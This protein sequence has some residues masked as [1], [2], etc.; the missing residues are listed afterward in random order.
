MDKNKVYIWYSGATDVTGKALVDKLGVTGGTEKPAADAEM[1]I[2]WGTKTSVDIKLKA[3]TVLN[4]PNDIRKNRNKLKAMEA[5]QVSGCN[6]A[7]FVKSVGK[8]D[9]IKVGLNY[10]LVGRTC[11]HQAG[12]G[13]WL[14]LNKTQ[15][16]AAINEGADYFQE[17]VHIVDEYRLHVFNDKVVYAVKKIRRNNMKEAFIEQ[18]GEKVNNAAAKADKKLD[19]D[20]LEYVLGKLAVKVLPNA[21]M[22]VR[23][24][25]RGWKFSKVDL[26]KLPKGLGEQAI[27]ALKGLNMS[28]GAVDCCLDETG[29]AWV[30]EVN[31]GPGL[32]GST[33]E[34]YLE[35]FNNIF[36]AMDK[37]AAEAVK[38]EAPKKAMEKAKAAAIVEDKMVAAKPGQVKAKE[39][40]KARLASKI[41]VLQ[42]MLEVASEDEAKVIDAL[43]NKM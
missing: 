42:K 12:K 7:P 26:N 35:E 28:F 21:D 36:V 25:L 30:I 18:Y 11:F 34:A 2:G 41:E 14:V 39:D 27:K 9:P 38:K 6:I 32:Q 37:K 33:L 3:G 16:D 22:I 5:M 4:H 17:Y 31:S 15:L 20:T 24:N 40:A 23:S 1:V 13:F 19:P 10:P 29:K 43:W 8:I